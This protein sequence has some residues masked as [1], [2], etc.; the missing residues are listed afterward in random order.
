MGKPTLLNPER[1]AFARGD[2]LFLNDGAILAETQGNLENRVNITSFGNHW[3]L[4]VDFRAA[5]T[6]TGRA[7]AHGTTWY[8]LEFVLP[9]SCKF[10]GYNWVAFSD[11]S[12]QKYTFNKNGSH[13]LGGG[14]AVT[15]KINVHLSVY[16][17]ALRGRYT[18]GQVEIDESNKDFG[19]DLSS[20]TANYLAAGWLCKVGAVI[21]ADAFQDGSNAHDRFDPWVQGSLLF[22][23]EHNHG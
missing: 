7:V 21:N 10:V 14:A 3:L 15:N 22:R 4:H 8:P 16:D 11:H 1:H 6:L 9:M 20:A 12:N 19:A 17:L 18:L 5:W 2:E 13:A 23:E